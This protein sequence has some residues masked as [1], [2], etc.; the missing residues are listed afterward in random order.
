MSDNPR[1]HDEDLLVDLLAAGEL[2]CPEIAR[3][4]GFSRTQ[5]WRIAK[6]QTRPDLQERI[7]LRRPHSQALQASQDYIRPL[8][9]T[10]LRVALETKGETARKAREYLLGKLLFNSTPGRGAKSTAAPTP[11]EQMELDDASVL[12]AIQ[13]ELAQ[14]TG[15]RPDPDP[16]RAEPD[17]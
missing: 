6:G 1:H 8:L 2:G 12:P 7:R 9:L 11:S 17:F 14:I 16:A 13:R 5:V 15:P 4:T 10:Q 3:R